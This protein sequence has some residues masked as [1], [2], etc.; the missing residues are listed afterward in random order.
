M[1][2]LPQYQKS[3]SIRELSFSM[4]YAVLDKHLGRINKCYCESR[5]AHN[6]TQYLASVAGCNTH[7]IFPNK[8]VFYG[9]READAFMLGF[10]RDALDGDRVAPTKLHPKV[11]PFYHYI[12]Q[13]YQFEDTFQVVEPIVQPSVVKILDFTKFAHIIEEKDELDYI[14]LDIRIPGASLTALYT[15]AIGVIEKV[16]A[17]YT[18]ED[19]FYALAV[20][21]QNFL[22][23]RKIQYV[24]WG[25]PAGLVREQDILLQM[26]Y[27]IFGYLPAWEPSADRP[28]FDDCVIFGQSMV[29]ID[30]KT[31]INV[32]PTGIHL[33]DL[34]FSQ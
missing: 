1:M 32:L 30:D 28:G 5:T 19:E 22:H 26:G 9:K 27:H 33:V 25:L 16:H 10:S 11:L 8:D 20:C 12:A 23:D 4:F 17:D 15:P 3:V 14:H 29:T 31:K 13:T 21:L 2:I 7:A 18:T 24:E 6:I 34:V